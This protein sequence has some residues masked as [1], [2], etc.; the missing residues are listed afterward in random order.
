MDDELADVPRQLSVLAFQI[1]YQAITD[2]L[3]MTGLHLGGKTS[4]EAKVSAK[5]VMRD[6][7]LAFIESDE[8]E[9]ICDLARTHHDCPTASKVRDKV[10]SHIAS[11]SIPLDPRELQQEAYR[12]HGTKDRY[13]RARDRGVLKAEEQRNEKNEKLG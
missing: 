6:E 13:V 1:L 12:I 4:P 8:L 10:R 7:V 11:G 2:A 3:G 5:A 9:T